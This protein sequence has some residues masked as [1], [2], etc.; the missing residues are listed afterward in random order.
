[1]LKLNSETRNNHE[2]FLS[3]MNIQDMNKVKNF[4]EVTCPFK[5]LKDGLTVLKKY[6]Q[7]YIAYNLRKLSGQEETMQSSGTGQLAGIHP[8]LL[9]GWFEKDPKPYPEPAAA[10]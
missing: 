10:D 9:K 6:H 3:R 8:S 1:M 7:S 2:Y 5:N 4:R